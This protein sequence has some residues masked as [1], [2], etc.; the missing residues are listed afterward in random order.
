[1]RETTKEKLAQAQFVKNID[2]TISLSQFDT[3]RL[4]AKYRYS[5]Y[6]LAGRLKPSVLIKVYQVGIDLPSVADPGR[7]H[8]GFE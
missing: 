5:I 2:L 4:L 3:Y 7:V 6:L 8:P 1:M